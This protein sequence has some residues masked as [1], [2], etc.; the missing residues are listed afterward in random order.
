M[1][2][3]EHGLLPTAYGLAVD[4]L[5]AA[6]GRLG[7]PRPG[8]PRISVHFR[9]GVVDRPITRVLTHEHFQIETVAGHVVR[10]DRSTRTAEI[11]GPELEPDE[12]IH[13][14]LAPIAA[15]HN[16]WLGREAF[17]AGAFVAAGRAW[18]VP[19]GREAGKSSLLA[20]LSLREVPVLADDLA[21]LE[22]LNVFSGPPCLDLRE[23]VPG[24]PEAGRPVR[25]ASRRRVWLDPVA[26]AVPLGGWVFPRWGD[27]VRLTPLP[28]PRLLRLLARVRRQPA[29]PSDALD[30]LALAGRPAWILERPRDWAYADASLDALL[31]TVTSVEPAGAS[32]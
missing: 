7:A 3:D 13:P 29:L 11:I 2:L 9:P 32:R 31:D 16:R 24:M 25:D 19:G 20:G 30:L 23:P 5:D 12:R 26:F 22:D 8:T 15:V 6:P 21:V 1:H 4:G 18:V 14:Y 10:A 17:H 28:A 27:A